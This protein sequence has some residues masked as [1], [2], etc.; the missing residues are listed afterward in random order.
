MWEGRRQ[1]YDPEVHEEHPINGLLQY[2]F[3]AFKRLFIDWR[4]LQ[5]DLY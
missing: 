5:F 3:N 1:N 2:N 4:M